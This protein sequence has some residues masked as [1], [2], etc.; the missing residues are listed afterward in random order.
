MG[1]RTQPGRGGSR[2]VLPRAHPR[3]IASPWPVLRY[4]AAV[5][6]KGLH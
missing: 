3:V 6:V 2:S 5:R 1:V 4:C